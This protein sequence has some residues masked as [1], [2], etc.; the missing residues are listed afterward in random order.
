MGVVALAVPSQ[1][2]AASPSAGDS[3]RYN[4]TRWVPHEM[5]ARVLRLCV[6]WSTHAIADIRGN[7]WGLIAESTFSLRFF[8]VPYIPI[9]MSTLTPD[10]IMQLG[11]GFWSSKTLLSAIEMELFTELA[12]HPEDLAKLQGQLGLHP[13]SAHDFLDALVALG[14]LR[15]VKGKYH[16]TPETGLF[17]DKN[18]PSY[19]GGMLEMANHR[20]FKFWGGLTRSEEHTSELQTH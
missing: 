2:G 7:T 11:L 3:R 18:K 1:L 13:R 8:P 6:A 20:L 17:L 12:K 19:I 14:F 15:R 16:N 9:S 10:K 4:G 5:R